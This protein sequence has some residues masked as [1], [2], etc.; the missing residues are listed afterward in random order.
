[1][2]ERA[3]AWSV[4]DGPRDAVSPR[5]ASHA[6]AVGVA[7]VVFAFLRLVLQ[8]ASP[9][10]YGDESAHLGKLFELQDMV[11]R[12]RSGLET[13]NRLALTGDAYPNTV[14]ALTLPFMDETRRID[15]ARGALSALAVL[16]AWVAMTVGARL[17]GRP[18][19]IAYVCLACLSPMVLAHHAVFLLDTA[20]IST[21]GISVLLCEAT[22]GFRHPRMTGAFVVAAALTLLTK[23]TALLWLAGPTAWQCWRAVNASAGALRLK[24]QRAAG[25]LALSVIGIAVIGLVSR[26]GWVQHWR[27]EDASAWGPLALVTTALVL[28][29]ALSIRALSA[30]RR[31]LLALTAIL[32]LA[33]TWYAMR[34]PLLLDRMAHEATTGI[35]E[36]GPTLHHLSMWIQTLRMLVQGGEIWLLIG[37]L[38]ATWR[39]AGAPWAR[40]VGLAIGV[41]MSIRFL[42]FNTRYLLPAAPLLAGI[43]VST[44][45]HESARTQWGLSAL[46]LGISGFIAVAPLPTEPL[47][48]TWSTDR[49]RVSYP[50]LAK[51]TGSPPAPLDEP[52]ATMML[53]TVA[54]MCPRGCSAHLT[55]HPHGI[56]DRAIRVLGMTRGLDIRFGQLC[57]GPEIPLPGTGQTLTLCDGAR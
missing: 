46:V 41:W 42:P 51:G 1:M 22:D 10:P 17:W 13:F 18:A 40:A 37:L 25:M 53:N 52:A 5:I 11:S 15:D 2:V 24:A 14:Y 21:V 3:V 6:W 39:R 57:T 19:A 38:L 16:H 44:W 36:T 50:N 23:W 54:A 55:P 35:P 29:A 7:A 8:E 32:I 33:G 20:L 48:Q 12:S 26:S 45:R 9:I 30:Y 56:Q 31:A 34:M 4:D 27:P 47:S 28:T 49:V 43:A